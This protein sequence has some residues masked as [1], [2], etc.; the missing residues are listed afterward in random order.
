MEQRMS[1]EEVAEGVLEKYPCA[2]VGDASN[3]DEV[4]Q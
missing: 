2:A 4:D 1:E 3:F